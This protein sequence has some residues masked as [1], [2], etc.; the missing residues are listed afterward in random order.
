MLTNFTITTSMKK[1]LGLT[2]IE[3]M[4]SLAAVAVLIAIAVPSFKSFSTSGKKSAAVNSLTG[5][6]AIARSEAVTRNAR[7]T[8]AANGGEDGA[9]IGTLYMPDTNLV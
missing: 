6:F 5:A 4:V 1:Q 7:M 2:L 3:L 8:L 9:D